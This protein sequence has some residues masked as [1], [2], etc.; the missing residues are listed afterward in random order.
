MTVPFQTVSLRVRYD[1]EAVHETDRIRLYRYDGTGAWTLVGAT[2]GTSEAV[3]TTAPL[4]PLSAANG[5]LG[6]FAVVAFPNTGTL[7]KVN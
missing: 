4:A 2:D 3:S 1:R 5:Y 6:W 7:I